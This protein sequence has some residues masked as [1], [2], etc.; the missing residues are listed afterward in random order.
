[1]T[2][3]LYWW[4]VPILLALVSILSA[5]FWPNRVGG[6]WTGSHWGLGNIV[7]VWGCSLLAAG[8]LIGAVIR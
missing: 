2:L 5:L 3:I 1:M 8:I 7:T 4:S 6:L